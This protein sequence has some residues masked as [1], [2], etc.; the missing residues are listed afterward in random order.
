MTKRAVIL[1]A[2]QLFSNIYNVE[3]RQLLVVETNFPN[4]F[5]YR[6]FSSA[7]I[8]DWKIYIFL[9]WYWFKQ[10][11]RQVT[12]WCHS[13]FG[14]P[15]AVRKL[16][17]DDI[18]YISWIQ[19]RSWLSPDDVNVFNFLIQKVSR[20]FNL[21]F[22][23]SLDVFSISCNYSIMMNLACRFK[24]CAVWLKCVSTGM[25]LGSLT[26][27]RWL[28]CRILKAVSAFPTY[29]ILQSLHSR[30]YM[31]KLL[32]QVVFGIF[33]MFCWFDCF[34]NAPFLLPVYNKLSLN[35][36]NMVNISVGKFVSC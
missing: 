35:L 18:N 26:S 14:V 25:A 31:M 23:I 21:S 16:N 36:K 15:D 33:E 32:L 9:I 1:V 5:G 29:W 6:P 27:F 11:C 8:L 20:D 10:I 3:K 24:L 13:G 34:W 17:L 22:S 7:F 12:G 30:K 19:F 28:F 4:C 2:M